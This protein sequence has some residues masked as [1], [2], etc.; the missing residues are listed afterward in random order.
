L[1]S[2]FLFPKFSLVSGIKK[3]DLKGGWGE[4]RKTHA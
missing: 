3:A 4:R 1:L 2:F